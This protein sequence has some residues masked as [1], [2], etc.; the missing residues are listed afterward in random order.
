V[1]REIAI[2]SGVRRVIVAGGDTSSHAVH[3]TGL[4]ALTFVCSLEPGAPLC[5]VYCEDSPLNGIEMV[6]K[7]GQIG[8]EDFFARVRDGRMR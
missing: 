3:Q 5:R 6:L 7:G 4:Y 2:H 8:P 1:L